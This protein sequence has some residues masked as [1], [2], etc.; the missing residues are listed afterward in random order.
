MNGLDWPAV[1]CRGGRPRRFV[2]VALG[3]LCVPPA[4]ARCAA[5]RLRCAVAI[6]F[7]ASADIGPRGI[8]FSEKW[9]N[10]RTSRK[11]HPECGG[12]VGATVSGLVLARQEAW[13][14]R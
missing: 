13:V 12:R 11:E 3:V 4:A 9:R 8:G 2:A 1:Y 6:F 5:Q 7:L 14:N 10:R